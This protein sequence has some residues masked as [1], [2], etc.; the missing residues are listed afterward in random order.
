VTTE[1]DPGQAPAWFA[2]AEAYRPPARWT[3]LLEARLEAAY[4][5]LGGDAAERARALAGRVASVRADRLP[6]EVAHAR[7]FIGP[8]EVLAPAYASLYLDPQRRIMGEVSRQVAGFYAE[9][10]LAPG[11]G[12]RDAPDNL[13]SELEFMYFLHFQWAQTGEV[14]WVALRERFWREHLG[15]WLP[16]LVSAMGRVRD[17]HPVYVALA[18]LTERVIALESE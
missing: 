10:G 1:R 5:P 4:A 11:E 14:R 9:A 15:R 12:P 17:G 16:Q 7:L 18:A 2:L 3:P 8:Y 6:A 13:L